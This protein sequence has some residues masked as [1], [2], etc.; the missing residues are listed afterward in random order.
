M[1]HGPLKEVFSSF[2]AQG[3]LFINWIFFIML[4][5]SSILIF[6]LCP[7][8]WRLKHVHE[9]DLLL[10][11]FGLFL[12]ASMHLL[13][14]VLSILLL[15]FSFPFWN[16]HVSIRKFLYFIYC[17]LTWILLCLRQ[18][19]LY[20]FLFLYSPHIPSLILSVFPTFPHHFN[21]GASPLHLQTSDWVVICDPIWN[22]F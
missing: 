19:P 8:I 3:L 12:H 22:S 7:F 14:F 21:L 10:V 2:N 4:I 17:I 5:R 18:A 9:S 13:K 6:I 1:C 16:V 11:S 20:Y 15:S